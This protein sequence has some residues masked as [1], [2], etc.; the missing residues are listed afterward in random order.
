MLCSDFQLLNK[1]EI[2]EQKKRATF[3]SSVAH[4]LRTPLNSIIPII[5]MVLELIPEPEVLKNKITGFLKIALNASIHLENV[6][7]DALD[8]TKIEFNKFTLFKKRF[9]IRTAV[10]EVADIMNFQM[11]QKNLAFDLKFS[12][13]V[14]KSI[15]S[16]EKRIKQ[17]LFNLLGNAIKFTFSGKIEI[18]INYD[19]SEKVLHIM[20]LD[21]GIGL[22]I[23]DHGKLFRFFG[24]FIESDDDDK[25]NGGMGLGLSITKKLIN[26][27]GGQIKVE[28]LPDIGSKFSFSIPLGDDSES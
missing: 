3:F 18:I 26:E 10:K 5:R 24:K 16:D 21:S 27:L 4:E 8:I 15:Y 13:T 19:Q 7:K 11:E 12:N 6:I 2:Y 23:E 20:I 14:P 28:S 17:V 22:R 25:N 1:I 9:D